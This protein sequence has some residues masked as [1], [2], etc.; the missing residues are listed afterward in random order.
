M[1]SHAEWLAFHRHLLEV[2][3][4]EVSPLL[5]GEAVPE[6]G[7]ILIGETGLEITWTFPDRRVLR[8]VTNLGPQTVPHEGPRPGWGHQIYPV[9]TWLGGWKELGPWT[10]RWYLS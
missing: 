7:L 9:G 5:R 4:R 1:P 10:V 6:T 3:A 2:R 8:L